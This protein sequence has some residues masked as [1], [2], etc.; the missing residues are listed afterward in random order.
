MSSFD[1]SASVFLHMKHGFENFC[2]DFLYF[3]DECRQQ[4]PKGGCTFLANET[5]AIFDCLFFN[6]FFAG[7]FMLIGFLVKRDSLSRQT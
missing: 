3:C 6:S 5:T 1:S 4:S 2:V 7:F